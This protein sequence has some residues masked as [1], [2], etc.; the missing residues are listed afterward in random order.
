MAIT[1][2][3]NAAEMNNTVIANT[4]S[5]NTTYGFSN[6]TV[7]VTAKT[8]MLATTLQSL[9][10]SLEQCN[11]HAFNSSKLT[12]TDITSIG[13]GERINVAMVNLI[14]T[15]ANAIKASYCSCYCN[16]CSCD[17]ARCSCN[18]N[19]CACDCNRCACDGLCGG[20]ECP[21]NV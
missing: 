20:G 14:E 12:L 6:N 9:Y 8:K 19:R 17:C 16:Y 3:M 21:S 13:V 4:N 15:K 18:C 7:N 10:I 5:M 2:S 1:T 11:N